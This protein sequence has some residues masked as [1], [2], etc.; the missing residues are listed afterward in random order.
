M[1]VLTVKPIRTWDLEDIKI[2]LGPDEGLFC[3]FQLQPHP[4]MIT[5]EDVSQ[6]PSFLT[7]KIYFLRGLSAEMK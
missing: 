3:F 1:L 2:V 7:F 6:A 4:S 5:T